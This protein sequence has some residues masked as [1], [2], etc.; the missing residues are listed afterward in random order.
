MV[1]GAVDFAKKMN[2]SEAVISVSIVAIGTSIPELAASDSNNKKEKGLSVGNIIGSNIFNIGSV[3][4]Y[5]S[6]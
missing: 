3:L 6:N 2:V 5:R 4:G 1:D